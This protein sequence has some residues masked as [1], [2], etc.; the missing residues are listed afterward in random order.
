MANKKAVELGLNAVVIAALLVGV[1]IVIYVIFTGF[2]GDSTN[3]IKKIKQGAIDDAKEGGTESCGG[4]FNQD[5][6]CYTSKPADTAKYTFEEVPGE[7]ADCKEKKCYER[8]E[9]NS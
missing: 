1:L 2:V 5:R 6:K 9:K 4:I 3:D 8:K 7:F